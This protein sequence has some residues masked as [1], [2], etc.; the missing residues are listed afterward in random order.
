MD[1]TRRPRKRALFI[2]INYVGQS[3]ELSGCVNDVVDMR[4]LL[5]GANYTETRVLYD[6]RWSGPFLGE[7]NDTAPTR[8]NMTSAFRWLVAGAGVGDQLFLHYSGHGSQLRSQ[9][10]QEA[11]GLDEVIV[12]VDYETA[13]MIRDDELRALLV[14]PLRGT[15]AA[16]RAVLDCCHSGTGIDLRYNLGF[17]AD[18]EAARGTRAVHGGT[19]AGTIAAGAAI[20][21]AADISSVVARLT[22]DAVRAELARW[23]GADA[24]AGAVAAYG[25]GTA[26]EPFLE[27]TGDGDSAI[28]HEPGTVERRGVQPGAGTPDILVLSGCAD[29]QTSADATFSRRANGALTYH[30]LAD[31]R[32]AVASGVWPPVTTL[33]R[34]LRR[35][36]RAAGFDQV[37]QI[38][39]EVPIGGTTC[40]SL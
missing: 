18:G 29:D 1:L 2:G 37:P 23:F 7:L 13:G 16:L 33:L 15:G 38:S 32:T 39:S 3:A 12:P 8:A 17:T 30:V 31:L 34:G 9:M 25:A 35:R 10:F 40:F 24:A 11:D 36:I 20:G 14:T 27:W 4:A 28:V 6:G 19:R 21:A 5:A 22:A 26:A